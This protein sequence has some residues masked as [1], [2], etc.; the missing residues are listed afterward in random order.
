MTL[1]QALDVADMASPM[2]YLARQALAVLRA[3]LEDATNLLNQIR[4]H[5]GVTCAIEDLPEAVA[6][7]RRATSVPAQL[8]AENGAKAALAGEFKEHVHYAACSVC[9]MF[10][11]IDGSEDD[12]SVRCEACDGDGR[13]W[14]DVYISWDNIKQIWRAGMQHFGVAVPR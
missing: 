6:A 12:E 1:V 14:M 4:D 5:A 13:L 3:R 11:N 9:D 7:L 10:G 2:P 8:T